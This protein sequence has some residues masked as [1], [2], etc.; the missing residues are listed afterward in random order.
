MKAKNVMNDVCYEKVLENLR[1]GYQVMVFVHARKDTAKTA[2]ALLE[3]AREKETESK[4]QVCR[5]FVYKLQ[6][7]SEICHENHDKDESSSS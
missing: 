6:R 4:Y 1:K 2:E 3:M 7:R 5:F